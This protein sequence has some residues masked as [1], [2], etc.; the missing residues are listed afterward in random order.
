MLR[1]GVNSRTNE[2]EYTDQKRLLHLPFFWIMQQSDTGSVT[3]SQQSRRYKPIPMVK[4]SQEEAI[5]MFDPRSFDS[6]KTSNMFGNEKDGNL[7]L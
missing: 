1:N 4:K 5:L 2:T 3:S 6:G 7:Y